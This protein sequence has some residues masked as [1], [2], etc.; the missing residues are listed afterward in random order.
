MT[1][2][3]ITG[4]RFGRLVAV[5]VSRAKGGRNGTFKALCDCGN[6]ITVARARLQSGHV[7][8]CGCYKRDLSSSRMRQ[9]GESKSAPPT[10]LG[11]DG[12]RLYRIW[13]AMRRRCTLDYPAHAQWF[14]KGIT[15]CAAWG[16]FEAF[17]DWALGAGYA[18]SLS[19]DR[20]N[21]D[22]NYEPGN[23]RWATRIEQAQNTSRT[24][25][26]EYKGRV[27][28]L[29]D[30][31]TAHGLNYNRVNQRVR[32]LG[33]SPVDALEKPLQVIRKDAR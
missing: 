7:Q 13:C 20:V 25:V 32:V 14:G 21:N 27:A 17:R 8:S 22:G 28:C 9:H 2:Q 15:I 30:H 23:C 11:A 4:Q 12:K 19:I 5:S 16:S 33:W 29:K 26:F 18:P 1:Y 31:C 3:D 6:Q 24:I 10:L